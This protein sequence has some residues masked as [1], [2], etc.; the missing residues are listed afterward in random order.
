MTITFPD[1]RLE[2][3][4]LLPNPMDQPLFP[5]DNPQWRFVPLGNTRGTLV[6]AGYD[7][8]D[9]RFLIFTGSIPGTGDLLD[10]NNFSENSLATDEQLNRYPTLFRYTSAEGQRYLIDEVKGLQSVTDPNG[11]TLLVSTNGLIWQ[12]SLTGNE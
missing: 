2:K 6:P 4:Q 10:L 7:E 8:P 3:F 11:N 9:G 12:N 1:G 5:I